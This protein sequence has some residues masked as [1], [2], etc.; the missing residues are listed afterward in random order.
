MA[1]VGLQLGLQSNTAFFLVPTSLQRG[2]LSPSPVFTCQ[3]EPW[4]ETHLGPAFPFPLSP[5]PPCS[6]V[7][8]PPLCSSRSEAAPCY[9]CSWW[10]PSVCLG[11]GRW[12]L[13][14]R[15]PHH[16]PRSESAHCPRAVRA[17]RLLGAGNRRRMVVY[18]SC[19]QGGL[20]GGGDGAA[21]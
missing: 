13:P 19:G 2:G 8:W 1:K 17:W 11:L 7:W 18:T 16:C 15:H 12:P 6:P 9:S 10:T 14:H 21:S 5:L 3:A 20:P 4:S